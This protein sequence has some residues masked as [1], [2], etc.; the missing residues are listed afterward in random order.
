MTRLSV[1]QDETWADGDLYTNTVEGFFAL[2]KRSM[3][4][5]YHSVSKKHLHRYVSQAEFLYNTRREDD[6]ERTAH[7][8]RAASGK[9]LTYR[10]LRGR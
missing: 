3:V 5:T 6:G 4:G 1:I 8:I 9:R 7:A 10:D 2:L